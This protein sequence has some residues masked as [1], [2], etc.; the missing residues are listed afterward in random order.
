MTVP[1]NSC[2]I[3]LMEYGFDVK[4]AIVEIDDASCTHVLAVENGRSRFYTKR[5]GINSASMY[6]FGVVIG[7]LLS[8]ASDAKI[9]Y[10]WE[11]L[12]QVLPDPGTEEKVN[13]QKGL[14]KLEKEVHYYAESELNVKDLSTDEYLKLVE[15]YSR[16]FP[17][18]GHFRDNSLF[19][20]DN[21]Y[22]FEPAWK[23]RD[24]HSA[25]TFKVLVEETFGTYRKDLAKAFASSNGS[26]ISLVAIFS[27]SVTAEQSVRL[28]SIPAAPALWGWGIVGDTLSN[29]LADLTQFNR[30]S[31]S[32][33]YRLIEDLLENLRTTEDGWSL[34]TMLE[35]T[36]TM[37]ETVK[38]N[39]LKRF[40]SDKTWDQV[41]GRAIELC[42]GDGD[43]K[44]GRNAIP[45]EVKNVEGVD[46]CSTRFAILRNPIDFQH[47]GE[48]LNNCMAKAGYFT[49]FRRGK[50]IS[51]IGFNGENAAIGLEIARDEGV[52]KVLQLNGVN[53]QRVDNRQEMEEV[54][55][56]SLN[57]SNEVRTISSK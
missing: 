34:S 28:L 46:I 24:Y 4:G 10:N 5:I 3:S 23:F 54:L 29:A 50:S 42:S 27:Q 9:S 45:I 53:N 21:F 7:Q 17:A 26:A 12:L 47:A 44:M 36:F 32:L 41:H 49:K 38:D 11:N 20:A 40:K 8:S 35:D 37:L 33:R 56:K 22:G 14:L 15:V 30:L 31:G 57:S 2:M 52:W 19:V 16:L 43:A 1:K 39:D 13:L 25:P 48:A 6:S 18:F 51:L 55:L